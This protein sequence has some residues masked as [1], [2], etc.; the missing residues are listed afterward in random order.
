MKFRYQIVTDNKVC[1]YTF[2]NEKDLPNSQ[3]LLYCSRCKEVCYVDADAQKSHWPI[4]KKACCKMV[5]EDRIVREGLGFFDYRAC[6]EKIEWILENPNE[7]FK[8]RLLLYALQWTR[9]FLEG[10]DPLAAFRLHRNRS[11]QSATGSLCLAMGMFGPHPSSAQKSFLGRLWGSPGFANY[12]LSEEIFLSKHMKELKRNNLMDQL[13]PQEELLADGTIDPKTKQDR[14]LQIPL[15]FIETTALLYH[16][17]GDPNR[18]NTETNLALAVLRT[19]M[20]AWGCPFVR[21]SIPSYIPNGLSGSAEVYSFSRSQFFQGMMNCNV[22]R[23]E[24]GL[25]D[26]MVKSGELLVG[27]TPKA[28]LTNM[29]SDEFFYLHTDLE[30]T[31]ETFKWLCSSEAQ[32]HIQNALSSSDRLFLFNSVQA[33]GPFAKQPTFGLKERQ[34]VSVQDLLVTVIVGRSAKNIFGMYDHMV[35]AFQP[36]S[37]PILKLTRKAVTSFR[38]SLISYS[39]PSV[40]AYLD[41]VEPLYIARVKEEFDEETSAFAVELS[42]IIAE[43]S[44]PDGG[45][46]I[47]RNYESTLEDFENLY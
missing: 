45:A 12:F 7:R 13:P 22:C 21:A 34:A 43:Y 11:I 9:H 47:P 20:K 42:F 10:I 6:C 25:S 35:D 30:Q 31:K 32:L 2:K 4:H 17:A 38:F 33:M 41:I 46:K 14:S 5:N 1:S 28:L 18:K 19:S 44:T 24:D 23:V 40:Q 16:S 26:D 3:K 29:I 36:P 8:G 39:L 37:Y 27:Q 15:P